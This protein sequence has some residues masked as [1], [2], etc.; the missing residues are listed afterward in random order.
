MERGR[1]GIYLL[2]EFLSLTHAVPSPILLACPTVNQRE[3]CSETT[4]SFQS[5]ASDFFYGQIFLV[6]GKK[7]TQH[8]CNKIEKT[9][10]SWSQPFSTMRAHF[11]K[12]EPHWIEKEP[13]AIGWAMTVPGPFY[14]SKAALVSSGPHLCQ[15]SYDTFC[16]SVRSAHDTFCPL[17][18]Y[19]Q[20]CPIN[21]PSMFHFLK[22]GQHT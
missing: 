21:P 8:H 2:Q 17:L 13:G 18:H 12:Q 6:G 22:G 20:L 14:R 3:C 5:L 4:V 10:L 15:F 1:A 9:R 11:R 19:A 7:N 16:L